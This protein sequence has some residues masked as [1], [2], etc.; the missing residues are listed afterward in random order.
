M[1]ILI[2]NDDSEWH[3]GLNNGFDSASHDTLCISRQVSGHPA[4]GIDIPYAVMIDQKPETRNVRFFCA[5]V[6]GENTFKI[7]NIKSI[8]IGPDHDRKP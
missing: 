4:G 5:A 7:L 8:R 2:Y 3:R 1:T 6:S